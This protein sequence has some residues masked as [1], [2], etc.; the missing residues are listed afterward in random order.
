[1]NVQL[2]L[3]PGASSPRVALVRAHVSSLLVGLCLVGAALA[4]GCNEGGPDAA[5]C[6]DEQPCADGL[7]CQDG[8][9]VTPCDEGGCTRGVCDVTTGLCV[10]C[11][12]STSCPEG[13]VCNEFTNRCVQP[14]SGCTSDE[15]CGG[16]RCDAT[17]GACVECLADGDC[18]AGLVCDLLTSTCAEEKACVTDG[19]CVDAVCDPD[20]RICVQCFSD[21]H[22]GAGT[23]DDATSTCV[24]G[25]TD[26]DVTE[27]NEGDNAALIADG[28]AHE[29]TI[30]PG[31][32]DELV[33]DAEGTLAA[34][35]TLDGASGLDLRLLGAAGNLVATATPAG[36]G[37]A[38]TASNLTAGTY[39]LVVSGLTAT[40]IGD[41]L[42][43]VD[44]QAPVTC[45][46]LDAEPNNST[47]QAATIAADN[48]LES[49]A[50]CGTDTDV[51][52]F[53][54]AQGDDLEA[55]VVPGDGAGTLALAILDASGNVVATGNPAT[56]ADAAAGTFFVR[57]TA[58][59]GD[60][61][62]SLR[63]QAVSGPPVCNQSDAEPNDAEAQA[64]ALTPGT[65]AS[66]TICPG[67]VDQHRFAAAALDDVTITVQ[68]SDLQA[69]LIRAADG[70]ELAAG[71]SMNVANLQAGGYRIVVQGTNASSQS[72]YT[73]QVALTPEPVADPCDEGGLE[74]D[75]H[76]APR[77]LAVDGTPLAGRVCT[78]DT[79]FYRFTLPFRSTVTVHTR[80]THASGDL[81]VDLVDASGAVI[82]SS[83]GITDDEIVVRTLEAG[84]YGVEVFGFLDAVNTYTIDATLQGCVP[85]DDFETNNTPGRATPIG[86][87]AVSAARCP[88]DDDFFLLRLENGDALDATLAGAGLT[89]SLVSPTDGA[90]LANDTASG[91]NRRLQVSGLPAGR[92]AVRVTGSGADRVAYTLTPSITPSVDRC[93]DDGASPNETTATAFTLDDT[94]LQ[95]GSYEVGALV[96]CALV[97]QDWFKI[98]L[99]GQKKVAVQLS[100]DPANDVD[101][102]LLEA[103][104]TS[105]LT[106]S[107][108]RSVTLD[109][110]DRLEGVLN[111]GGQFF[112]EAI[113]FDT[114]PARYGIGIEISDPPASSCVDDRFD[115]FTATASA[116]ETDT[117][118]NNLPSRAV[119]LSSGEDLTRLRICPGNEDWYEVNASA[120]QHIVVH[121]DYA[122]GTGKDIDLRLFNTASQTEP[123]QV[124]SSV[125]TDGTE[126][127]DFTVVTSGPHFIKVFGFQNGENLYDLSVDVR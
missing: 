21:A 86:A 30:C 82:T 32:V 13:L 96:T 65:A 78:A 68:G 100:F 51:F 60:V 70:V 80:F 62:Y 57:V 42:L 121:I 127:I 85:D 112:I 40:D 113:G 33:I 61:T 58:T 79:D 28:G 122:H 14:I 76:A 95:D 123:N 55:T 93:V 117:F 111:V 83:A 67:D 2:I 35:L 23:C 10:D 45:T 11:L 3:S 8:A 41:Y 47:G 74:P 77:A 90:V 120:G 26:D 104:G 92:Y 101:V 16:L 53:S 22:C 119:E 29:G 88:G 25:C 18:G 12:D 66:G 116:T 64:L 124:A 56:V 4:A 38:L 34:T 46:Q 20:T 69:R 108:A 72:S 5:G 94:G 50:I 73:I 48:S 114:T 125:D 109:S 6:S 24:V 87:A 103:R 99:P 59:G 97:D 106:R 54:A 15:E 27:P 7:A 91:A 52:R 49:G 115:T 37:L 84:T 71:A 44:V 19:D 102:E 75:S 9:C 17:K 118:D 105:G 63:V 126:D 31:D 1:M 39:R 107:L 36:G 43:S 81:D 98:A 89:M 110:Q